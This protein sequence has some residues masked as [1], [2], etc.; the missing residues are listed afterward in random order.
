MSTVCLAAD[1]GLHTDGVEAAIAQ[2]SIRVR[3]VTPV[4]QSLEPRPTRQAGP[5][6]IVRH[7]SSTAVVTV[8]VVQGSI[9]RYGR[10]RRVGEGCPSGS[11]R[12]L[13]RPI[14]RTAAE[15]ERYRY[16]AKS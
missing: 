12:V 15:Q 4:R 3:D 2:R 6:P 16:L 8:V 9:G 11:V 10:G 13:E 14:G 1:V 7:P 5:G